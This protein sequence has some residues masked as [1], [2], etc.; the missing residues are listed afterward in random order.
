VLA[1]ATMRMHLTILIAVPVICLVLGRCWTS[2]PRIGSTCAQFMAWESTQATNHTPLP[3]T[4]RNIASAACQ[5]TGLVATV[6]SFCLRSDHIIF[7]RVEE[8]YYWTNGVN[9]KK[10]RWIWTGDL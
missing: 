1:Q 8:I 5:D 3:F 2:S 4:I 6:T 10:S 9:G 7:T